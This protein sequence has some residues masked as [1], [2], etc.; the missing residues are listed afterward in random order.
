MV[1]ADGASSD[2]FILMVMVK[3]MNTLAPVVTTNSGL[4]LFE[5]QSRPLRADRNLQVSDENNLQDVRVSGMKGWRGCERQ[6][7]GEEF[8]FGQMYKGFRYSYCLF[9]KFFNM[10]SAFSVCMLDLGRVRKQ[11]QR[12]LEEEEKQKIKKT[13]RN[14]G[15]RRRRRRSRGKKR[16]KNNNIKTNK[17]KG[18]T[19]NHMETFSTHLCKTDEEENVERRKG[20]GVGDGERKGAAAVT[21][22]LTRFTIY[23]ISVKISD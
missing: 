14:S 10:K 5:G 22:A 4:Q 23:N 2:P 12:R 13:R 11:E 1:D 15:R 9:T 17:R 7:T 3:P 18:K 16:R 8:P 21:T 19:P 20:V 6:D